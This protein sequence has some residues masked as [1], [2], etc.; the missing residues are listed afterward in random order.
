M[1]PGKEW[2]PPSTLILFS[3]N[4]PLPSP[5]VGLG[6]VYVM[7]GMEK[8]MVGEITTVG[9]TRVSYS[10]FSEDILM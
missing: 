2:A 5:R 1:F 3:S 10:K 7:A 9:K 4:I 8:K 6:A